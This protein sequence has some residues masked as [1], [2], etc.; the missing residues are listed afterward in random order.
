MLTIRYRGGF[1]THQ[2]GHRILYG[3]KKGFVFMP[4]ELMITLILVLPV[5]ILLAVFVCYLNIGR[6]FGNVKENRR[7]QVAARNRL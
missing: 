1:K 2:P 6:T 5:F 7:G 3:S 4:L